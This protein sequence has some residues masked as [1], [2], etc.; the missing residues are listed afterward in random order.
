VWRDCR[1]TPYGDVFYKR[2]PSG[3]TAVKEAMSDECRAMSDGAS[4]VRG[5][6]FLPRDMGAGHSCENGDCP[7]SNSMRCSG[8]LSPVFAKP[9]LLNIIGRKVLDL[10][11]GPNDVSRLA[12]GVYFVLEAHA[13]AQAQAQ[14]ARKAVIQR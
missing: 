12:P 6:L 1:D 2:N 11:P 7:A 10:K 9:A 5:V 14:A 4:I 13:Q 3:N 8:G